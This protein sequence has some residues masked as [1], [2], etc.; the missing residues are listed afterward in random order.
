MLNAY[1]DRQPDLELE[2]TQLYLAISIVKLCADHHS[3]DPDDTGRLLE[4]VYFA[5]EKAEALRDAWREGRYGAEP[6]T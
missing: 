2:I 1:I 6:A 3:Y 4:A 5:A